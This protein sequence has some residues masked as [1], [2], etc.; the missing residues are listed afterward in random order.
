MDRADLERLGLEALRAHRG[1]KWQRYP[2]DILPAWVA[3]LDLP[4]AD[5]IRAVVEQALRVHDFGYPLDGR[6]T[7]I[8]EAFCE[9]M[10][11][12]YRWAPDPGQV[13]VLSD[14]VQGVYLAVEA[15]SEPGDGVAIQTPIYPPFLSCV[16]D[17]GR[18]LVT[19]PLLEADT[20][21]EL[22]LDGLRDAPGHTRISFAIG[23]F[24]VGFGA[25]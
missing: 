7:G 25:L 12:R 21:F 3:E 4:V 14:V 15:L 19:N 2:E 8:P 6:K 5:P 10:E 1:E 24:E 13:D 20:R 23:K 22:D 17:T 11:R 9:R 18:R 16:D